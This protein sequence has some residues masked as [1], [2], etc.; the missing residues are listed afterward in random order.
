MFN[1]SNHPDTNFF[2]E[3][4]KS[5]I[6]ASNAAALKEMYESSRNKTPIFIGCLFYELWRTNRESDLSE[7]LNLFEEE[8]RMSFFQDFNGFI[9]TLLNIS[10]NS[11]WSE[12]YL[13]LIV[14]CSRQCVTILTRSV[15]TSS[16]K[17]TAELNYII[18]VKNLTIL[19]PLLEVEI[20]GLF[21]RGKISQATRNI[22]E[23]P[24]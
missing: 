23:I 13:Q 10:F 22:L 2:D 1:Q 17:V 3:S 21:L 18:F 5:R 19:N 6:A 14:L 7:F 20:K 15:A 8:K 9:A 11:A 12:E 24:S 16:P 4:E